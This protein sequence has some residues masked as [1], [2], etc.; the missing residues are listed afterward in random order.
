M[1]AIDHQNVIRC[2]DILELDGRPVLILEMCHGSLA[3]DL[4]NMSRSR[5]LLLAREILRG[6]EH[7]HTAGIA[8]C[9]LKPENIWEMGVFSQ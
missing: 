5:F 4:G 3:D 7:C 1:R 8:H 6:L 9:D 2:Y